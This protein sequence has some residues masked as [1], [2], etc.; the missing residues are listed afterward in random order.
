MDEDMHAGA[1]STHV[2]L[3]T[4]RGNIVRKTH[5]AAVDSGARGVFK[6][7]LSENNK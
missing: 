7:A 1:D 4:V 3:V 5:G 6:L 2:F